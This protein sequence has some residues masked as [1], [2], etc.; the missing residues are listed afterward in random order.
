M[1]C[2]TRKVRPCTT[3]RGWSGDGTWMTPSTARAARSD[4][5]VAG[6][7]QRLLRRLHAIALRG[8]GIG[9]GDLHRSGELLVL[10]RLAQADRLEV[11]VDVGANV[12]MYADFASQLV[13]TA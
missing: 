3:G 2:C 10:R 8:L 6:V 1:G 4:S 11:I 5:C 9:E 12:G 13:P 7:Q